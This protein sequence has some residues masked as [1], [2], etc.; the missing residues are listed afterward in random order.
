MALSPADIDVAILVGGLGSRLRAVVTDRPKP[1]AEVAGAPFLAHLLTWLERAGFRRVVL[2]VG[3]GGA[4]VAE[5]FGTGYGAL[6]LAYAWEPDELRGTGG[7]LVNAL[8]QLCSPIVLALNGDSFCDADLAA[9]LTWYQSLPPDTAAALL[10]T[11]VDDTR[12]YGRVDS[13]GNTMAGGTIASFHEKG[14]KTGPGTINAGV[15]LFARPTL[16]ALPG[17]RVLSLEREV[18]PALIGHGLYGW[19]GGGR[20]IDI[21]TPE[22]YAAADAFFA[23]HRHSI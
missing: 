10:L 18:F 16:A 11:A 3:H 15:Y 7:A 8:P 23:P 13:L 14:E 12:R 6:S 17:D 20:F 19:P 1:L 4:Q 5:Q 21:G 9:F 2:C 22:S